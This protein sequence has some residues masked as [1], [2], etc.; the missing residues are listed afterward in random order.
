MRWKALTGRNGVC[1][2]IQVHS[3]ESTPAYASLLSWFRPQQHWVP[4]N[5]QR[6]TRCPQSL[7]SS[8]SFMRRCRKNTR[9]EPRFSS[10][11]PE[12]FSSATS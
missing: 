3:Y 11:N 7:V 2:L 1:R 5:K 6:R 8:T 9:P 4:S 10:S 12:S